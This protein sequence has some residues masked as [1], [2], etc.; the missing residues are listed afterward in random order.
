MSHIGPWI[1]PVNLIAP[2]MPH[3]AEFTGEQ[4][5]RQAAARWARLEAVAQSKQSRPPLRE[6]AGV[7]VSRIAERLYP[8]VWQQHF[9]DR[10]VGLPHQG[11][12][13]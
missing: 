1:D 12:T 2:T 13:R 6:R 5:S 8:D 10:S 11:P 4:L 9:A 3:S 7:L